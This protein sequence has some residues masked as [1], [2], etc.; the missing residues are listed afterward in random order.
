MTFARVHLL[1][2][3]VPLKEGEDRT[4]LCGK[5]IPRAVWAFLWDSDLLGDDMDYDAITTCRDCFGKV[6]I[7]RYIYGLIPGESVKQ[8]EA[9]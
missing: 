7:K 6:P 3:D 2:S 5:K 4:A 9:E 1:D 8:G